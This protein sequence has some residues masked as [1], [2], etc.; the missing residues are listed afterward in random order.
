MSTGPGKG[1]AGK[2][3]EEAPKGTGIQRGCKVP[4]AAK[5]SV[6]FQK[7]IGGGGERSGADAPGV[8]G[9]GPQKLRR[10]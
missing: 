9:Q 4:E 7:L 8:G 2:N 10:G 6:S 5:S 1:V 3:M